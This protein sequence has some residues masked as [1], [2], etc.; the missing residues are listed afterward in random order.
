MGK[1]I[2]PL[3]RSLPDSDAGNDAAAWHAAALP[4]GRPT[5]P[6]EAARPGSRRRRS[7]GR[8]S[9]HHSSALL[10][11]QSVVSATQLSAQP[12]LLPPP[13]PPPPHP[14]LLLGPRAQS[15]MVSGSRAP[16]TSSELGTMVK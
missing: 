8:S 1:M 3:V 14:L 9:W 12:L 16:G 10:A 5:P 7:S 2:T 13:P 4:T 6:H 11:A 15:T